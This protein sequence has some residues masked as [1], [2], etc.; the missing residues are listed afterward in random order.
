MHSLLCRFSPLFILIL[1]GSTP[2]CVATNHQMAYR[3][4]APMPLNLPGIPQAPV[5][6]TLETVIIYKGP[7]SWK[8]RAFWDEYVISVANHGPTAIRL[9]SASLVEPGGDQLSPGTDWMELE[10][11]SVDGWKRNVTLDNLALGAELTTLTATGAAAT[12]TMGIAATVGAG[13]VLGAA[14]GIALVSL[15][16]SHLLGLSDEDSRRKIEAEFD[17]RR[18][19]IPASLIP[20]ETVRG[21]LF[22]R[23]TPSPQQLQLNYR[24]NSQMHRITINLAS[25]HGLHRKKSSAT[26]SAA[27]DAPAQGT[28]ATR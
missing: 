5:K 16:A 1:A 7:G 13:P 10:R 21:S 23:I 3:P 2:G 26:A 9:Q 20:G 24:A 8:E 27:S 17:Q 6:A 4:T 28:I 18:L 14:A 11:Q 25:L 19:R 12:A 22:F 15:G